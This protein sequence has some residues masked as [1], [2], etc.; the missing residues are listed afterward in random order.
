MLKETE[1][2]EII[3]FFVIFLSLVLFQLDGVAPHHYAYGGCKNDASTLSTT[4]A[5]DCS[6]NLM[7]NTYRTSRG[8]FCKKFLQM[9]F[10]D[11]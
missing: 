5:P 3:E 8:L 1:T 10:K 11:F 9:R 6:S 4:Y 7:N 2:E